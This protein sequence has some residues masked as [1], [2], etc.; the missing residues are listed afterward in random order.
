VGACCA[1]LHQHFLTR[2]VHR[3]KLSQPLPQPLQLPAAHRAFLA[4]AID[5]LCVDIK[6]AVLGQQFDRDARASLLPRLGQQSLLKPR[7]APFRRSHQVLHRRV[8]GPHLRQHRFGGNAAI[9]HP[10]TPRATILLLDPGEEHPQRR[11]VSRIAGQHLVGQGQA[12]RGDHQRDH[13]LRAVRPLVPAVAVATLVVLRHRP[14][15]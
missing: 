4:D 15:R 5:A 2:D 14:R 9:H 12:V 8:A 6:F 7:E 3:G 13:H 11:A 1:Q 10:D